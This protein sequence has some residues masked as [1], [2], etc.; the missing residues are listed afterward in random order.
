MQTEHMT[1]T[2][3]TEAAGR[4][5]QLIAEGVVFVAEVARKTRT[6]PATITRQMLKGVV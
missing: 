2:G 4:V 1:R 6:H 5:G 3:V